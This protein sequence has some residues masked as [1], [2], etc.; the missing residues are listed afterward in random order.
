VDWHGH[1]ALDS[2]PVEPGA[3]AAGVDEMGDRSLGVDG[4]LE[5]VA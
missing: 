3:V 2:A 1:G 5:M 4:D